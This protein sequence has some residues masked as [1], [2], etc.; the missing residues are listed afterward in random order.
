[1]RLYKLLANQPVK[2]PVMPSVEQLQRYAGTYDFSGQELKILVDGRRLYVE[3]PGE[4]RIRMLPI[5]D[6]EFWIHSLQAVV[7]FEDEGG[8]IARAVFSVGDQR[9]AAP[10]KP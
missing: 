8:K 10:R 6:H 7:S 3:G 9:M 5:S 2:A 4:P 1:M